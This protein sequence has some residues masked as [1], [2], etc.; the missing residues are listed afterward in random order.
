M[1]I[2]DG[3]LE[4]SARGDEKPRLVSAVDGYKRWAATYDRDPNPLL[5]RE[6]RH[7]VSLL[8]A[9]AGK[10]VLDLACGTGRWLQKCVDMGL[11]FSVGVDISPSMLAIASTKA[12]VS[13]RIA[14]ADCSEL[15]FGDGVFDLAICSFAIWHVQNVNLLAQEL[16]RVT[17]PGATVLLSD[18]HPE[19]HAQGWRTGFRDSGGPKQIE[20]YAVAVTELISIFA[21]AGLDCMKAEALWLGAPEAS[22]FSDAGKAHLFGAAIRVPAI[23]AFQFRRVSK[24]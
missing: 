4:S 14:L 19:A 12:G 1:S 10:R 11:E 13:Q 15:P 5:H 2:R 18:V 7:W 17:K 20:T 3:V 24:H 9:F 22:I 21:V 8:P 23:A 6:E 16:A